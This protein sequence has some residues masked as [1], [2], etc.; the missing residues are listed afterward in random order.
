MRK[1]FVSILIIILLSMTIGVSCGESFSASFP[2]GC[3]GCVDGI[4]KSDTVIQTM[5]LPAGE[6]EL[7]I[8]TKVLPRRTLGIVCGPS[9]FVFRGWDKVYPETWY[10]APGD[11]IEKT[12]TPKSKGDPDGVCGLEGEEHIVH[13][14]TRLKL[15]EPI[16]LEIAMDPS[17]EYHGGGPAWQYAQQKE[18]TISY[19]I[20]GDK[21]IT[22][23]P[24]MTGRNSDICS[25]SRTY[26]SN[27]GTLTL[28]QVGQDAFGTYTHDEGRISGTLT[29]KTFRGTWSEAPSYT[30][31][32]DAG[33]CE[34]IFSDDCSSFTGHWR[35]GFT[36]EWGSSAEWSGSWSGTEKP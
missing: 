16:L 10:R 9:D 7:N 1:P 13:M 6:L 15:S 4:T 36:G 17:V 22:P 11:I 24:T 33:E 14:I 30:P 32:H 20:I 26:S 12:G 18:I 21:K 3:I 31:P 23:E 29:G 34:F 2:E 25:I 27:Q 8:D 5:P 28:V 19:T 35:Y